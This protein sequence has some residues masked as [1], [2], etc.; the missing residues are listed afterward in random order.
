M[1]E[2]KQEIVARPF[3]V[4]P[5]VGIT[6]VYYDLQ[7]PFA[8]TSLGSIKIIMRILFFNS[9]QIRT[10]TLSHPLAVWKTRRYNNQ[11][12]KGA[13]SII[14]DGTGNDTVGCNDSKLS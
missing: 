3:R 7:R 2:S 4:A 6:V 5:S 11:S 10:V 13:E 12:K 9:Q 1:V 8:S 14:S